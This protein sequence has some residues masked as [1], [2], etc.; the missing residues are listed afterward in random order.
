MNNSNIFDKKLQ[1]PEEM[2]NLK[3]QLPSEHKLIKTQ[4]IGT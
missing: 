2:Q 3:D 4:S 1:N